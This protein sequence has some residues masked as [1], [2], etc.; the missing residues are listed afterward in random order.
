MKMNNILLGV[1]TLLLLLLIATNFIYLTPKPIEGEIIPSDKGRVDDIKA[2][3]SLISKLRENWDNGDYKS[4]GNLFDK[5]AEY[6][7]FLGDR[8]IGNEQIAIAHQKLFEDILK[9]SKMQQLSIK[10][11]RFLSE[12]CAI[13]HLTGAINP[14]PQKEISDSR[15][16]IQTLTATKQNGEWKFSSFQNTRIQRL[17]LFDVLIGAI[18]G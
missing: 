16:S 5:Q 11:I 10:R 8:L 9:G 4:Y 2:I 13:I 6:I 18:K 1:I 3:E 7:T 12:N 15:K 14:K 17:S